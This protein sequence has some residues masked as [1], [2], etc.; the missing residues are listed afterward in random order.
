MTIDVVLGSDPGVSARALASRQNGARSRGPKT[1]AGKAR[2]AR[3]ALKH[4]LC[5]RKL[6]VL[7]EEDAAAFQA[8]EVALLEELAPVGALQAVLAARVVSAAWR[9]MRADRLEAE[10]L[11]FRRSHEGGLGL[12]LMRDGNGTRSFDT[13][14]RYRGAATAELMRALKTLQALQA[15]ARAEAGLPAAPARQ[16]RATTT[17]ARPNEPE[18]PRRVNG[19][20]PNRAAETR[21]HAPDRKPAAEPGPLASAAKAGAPKSRADLRSP[22]R[23]PDLSATHAAPAPLASPRVGTKRTQQSVSNQGLDPRVAGRSAA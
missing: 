7:P 8:L 22:R 5:A 1:A 14:M 3:N 23:S 11:E 2:S 12:A 6:L 15:E 20:T 18:Q 13:V 17:L 10:V 16:R 9:L 4:G 19:A 21:Q